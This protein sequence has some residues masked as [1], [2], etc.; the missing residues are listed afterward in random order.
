MLF[1]LL[2]RAEQKG[3]LPSAAIKM[4]ELISFLCVLFVCPMIAD[5]IFFILKVQ[6]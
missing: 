3:A 2:L 6:Q 1:F 4:R 5:D